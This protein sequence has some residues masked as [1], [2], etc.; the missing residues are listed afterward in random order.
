MAEIGPLPPMVNCTSGVRSAGGS[1][2]QGVLPAVAVDPSYRRLAQRACKVKSNGVT[3]TV[4]APEAA[5]A[6]SA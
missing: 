3:V 4:V 2:V 5:E 6:S 1:Q